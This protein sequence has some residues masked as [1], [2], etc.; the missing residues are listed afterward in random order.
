MRNSDIIISFSGPINAEMS[1]HLQLV[2]NGLKIPGA[3]DLNPPYKHRCFSEGSHQSP[4]P[5]FPLC[6]PGSVFC[7]VP[8][9]KARIF[10]LH[11][12]SALCKQQCR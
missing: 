2:G 9:Q 1:S 7:T 10:Y 6:D 8:F 4:V 3:G 12:V 5:N 11:D